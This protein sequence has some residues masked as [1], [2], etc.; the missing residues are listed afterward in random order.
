MICSIGRTTCWGGPPLP[1]RR[2]RRPRP[3]GCD[4]PAPCSTAGSSGAG[5]RKRCSAVLPGRQNH[6]EF[7]RAQIRWG[8]AF[9][10]GR[11]GKLFYFLKDQGPTKKCICHVYTSIEFVTSVGMQELW[12]QNVETAPKSSQNF[13]QRNQSFRPVLNPKMFPTKRKTSRN[14]KT[15]NCF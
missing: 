8:C 15:L 4:P 12:K 11:K 9:E 2:W 10:P 5:R 7:R 1:L 6:P 13:L 3:G 14:H